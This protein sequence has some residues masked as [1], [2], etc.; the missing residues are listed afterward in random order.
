M[1][2]FKDITGKRYGQLTALYVASRN[3][4]STRSR[5][6]WLCHC[7]C[8]NSTTVFAGNLFQGYT[9]SC[10]C[11][12][13]L[14]K[15]GHAKTGAAHPLYRVW[16]T[17]RHRCSNP[18]RAEYKNYGGRGIKVCKQWNDFTTFLSDVGERPPGFTLDRIDNDGDY[19]PSNIR[20]VGRTVQNYNRRKQIECFTTAE[21]E[22]ELLRR[23]VKLTP[24]L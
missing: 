11:K 16:T 10:G 21:L 15:H 9:R 12:K 8:G 23:H 3:K 17:M 20:W 1:P 4:I 18:K 7:D 13:G 2:K 19:E 5:I 14:Y 24:V 22:A 6:L